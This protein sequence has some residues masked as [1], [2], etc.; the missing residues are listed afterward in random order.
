M[1]KNKIGVK[2]MIKDEREMKKRSKIKKTIKDKKR[3]K[4]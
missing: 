3:T 2:K 4:E 1:I